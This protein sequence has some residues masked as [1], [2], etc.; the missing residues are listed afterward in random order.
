MLFISFISLCALNFNKLSRIKP[1][2]QVFIF[3]NI[4]NLVADYTCP[5]N[6]SVDI[7]MRMPVDPGIDPAVGN[8]VSAFTGKGAKLR[9]L[10]L[11]PHLKKDWQMMFPT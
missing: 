5:T 3:K 8:H 11:Q 4:S 6:H 7:G 2:H 10:V 1:V 9:S